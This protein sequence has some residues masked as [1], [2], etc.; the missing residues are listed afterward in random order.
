MARERLTIKNYIQNQF[1]LKRLN[2]KARQIEILENHRMRDNISVV[3]Q[4]IFRF[5]TKI[6]RGKMH[7]VGAIKVWKICSLEKVVPVDPKESLRLKHNT[8]VAGKIDCLNIGDI[9]KRKDQLL[10]S[11]INE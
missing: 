2:L 7:V 8:N 6:E 4:N 10:G 11:G 3:M 9:G 1:H 5:K